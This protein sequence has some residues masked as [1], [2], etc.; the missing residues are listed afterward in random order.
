MKRQADRQAREQYGKT[1]R[2]RGLVT[3]WKDKLTDRL[4]RMTDK[5]RDRL[6]RMTDKF[7]DKLVRMTDKFRDR[8]VNRKEGDIFRERVRKGWKDKL[9]DKL[10]KRNV[11]STATNK[12]N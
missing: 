7:R 3:G 5:F 8:L 10:L 1:H 12:I 4:V 2:E 11:T 9:R 6:V